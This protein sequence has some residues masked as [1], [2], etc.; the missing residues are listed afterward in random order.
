MS[1][2]PLAYVTTG[3]GGEIREVQIERRPLDGVVLII[4]A[5]ADHRVFA[6][7]VAAGATIR[8]ARDAFTVLT[9]E[10]N[11]GALRME[12][13]AEAFRHMQTISAPVDHYFS[14]NSGGKRKAQWKRERAG[15]KS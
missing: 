10:S 14:D 3:D 5:G 15:R 1:E 12:E 2:S 13:M 8:D 9:A 11:H 7:L 6:A 4:G